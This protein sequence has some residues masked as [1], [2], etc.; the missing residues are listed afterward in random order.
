MARY[1]IEHV[2][3]TVV[4]TYARC[5][6]LEFLENKIRFS[7]TKAYSFYKE[8]I[9]KLEPGKS[10]DGVDFSIFRGNE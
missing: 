10:Y 6:V 2:D 8:H 9:A 4:R 5:R 3:G 1:I 7:P